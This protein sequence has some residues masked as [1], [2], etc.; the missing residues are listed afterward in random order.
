MQQSFRRDLLEG[1]RFLFVRKDRKRAKVLY[2][3]GTGVCV[4]AK[5]LSTGQFLAPW[6][7]AEK[8]ISLSEL[9]LFIEGATLGSG[10]ARPCCARG[11]EDD[12]G[13]DRGLVR[14]VRDFLALGHVRRPKTSR[15]CGHWSRYGCRRAP[16]KGSAG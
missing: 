6:K 15:W 3:D 14:M 13:R 16:A 10:S 2:F 9:A 11:L 12:A 7:M 8:Q 1:A 5:R 4:F